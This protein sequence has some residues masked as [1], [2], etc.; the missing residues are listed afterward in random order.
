MV[1]QQIQSIK[2][3]NESLSIENLIQNQDFIFDIINK[4]KVLNNPYMGYLIE[5]E[6]NPS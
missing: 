3:K 4:Y 1:T 2:I 5:S 6:S